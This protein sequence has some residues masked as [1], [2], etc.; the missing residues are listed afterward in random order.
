[1]RPSQG[2]GLFPI[3]LL[4]A[5]ID[6]WRP[7]FLLVSIVETLHQNG[8]ALFLPIGWRKGEN[9]TGDA[10][11]PLLVHDTVDGLRFS[12]PTRPNTI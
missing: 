4:A 6:E 11:F 10:A 9:V 5:A 8:I 3:I 1:M 7:V 12:W 2:D